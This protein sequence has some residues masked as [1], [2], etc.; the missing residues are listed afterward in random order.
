MKRV[1]EQKKNGQEPSPEDSEIVKKINDSVNEKYN[2][3]TYADYNTR[4]A[5]ELK[6]MGCVTNEADITGA[7]GIQNTFPEIDA[8][9]NAIDMG[10]PMG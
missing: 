3:K 6:G 8:Q 5:F 2:P 1:E 10:W 4:Y 7:R 9:L